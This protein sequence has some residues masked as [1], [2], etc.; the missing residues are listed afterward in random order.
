MGTVKSPKWK[1]PLH[2]QAVL[3]HLLLAHQLE[4]PLRQGLLA[5]G[6]QQKERRAEPQSGAWQAAASRPRQSKVEALAKRAI[7]GRFLGSERNSGGD[8]HKCAVKLSL[9]LCLVFS[10]LSLRSALRAACTASVLRGRQERSIQG[11][12]LRRPAV[13]ASNSADIFSS[14]FS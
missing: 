12:I 14:G 1:A 9:S 4:A 13:L 10:H 5:G 7:G 3:L 2:A 8:R 11:R 6:L